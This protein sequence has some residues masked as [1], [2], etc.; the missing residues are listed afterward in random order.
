MIPRSLR[1]SNPQFS[2]RDFATKIACG[3][4]VHERHRLS[5]M[6]FRKLQDCATFDNLFV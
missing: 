6:R 3:L 5:R 1:G 2:N 4:R